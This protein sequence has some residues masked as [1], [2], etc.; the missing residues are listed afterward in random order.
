[1]A[2]EAEISR[3][4]PGCLVF[5]VDQS[6]SMSEQVETGVPQSKAIAVAEAINRLLFE[7][8]VKCGKED[9][10]R[11]YF[12]V[13]VVGYGVTVGSAFVGDLQGRGLIPISVIADHPAYMSQ[14]TV[15]VRDGSNGFVE[16]AQ[17]KPVWVEPVALGGTPM[18]QALRHA[19]D[20]VAGWV[21]AHPG[22][23]PPIVLNLTDG[24]STDGD[25]SESGRAIGKHV[26][27]DGP[28]LLFNLHVSPGQHEAVAYPDSEEELPNDLS[29]VLFSMSSV[30][31]DHMQG[32]AKLLGYTV[33]NATRGFV[34][35]G[36]ISS[37]VQFLDIG[38][39]V[40]SIR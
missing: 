34:Y 25:P 20:L 37:V 39:R 2:Y 13:A 38:T 33:S 28:A 6:G 29:R 23:F 8:A 30:L 35:N 16:A 15:L 27:A 18:N 32:Y 26:T 21:S 40:T 9:T 24:A 19:E 5:L 7:L 10:V 14:Q 3:S 11:D 31:P 1:M 36:D 17:G 22:G 4:N 12:H